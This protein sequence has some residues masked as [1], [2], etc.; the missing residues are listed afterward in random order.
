MWAQPSNALQTLTYVNA[1]AKSIHRDLGGLRYDVAGKRLQI[2]AA[3]RPHQLQVHIHRHWKLRC[4]AQ[5]L[6]Q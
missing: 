3:P 4:Q 6:L 2:G 5:A 1:G